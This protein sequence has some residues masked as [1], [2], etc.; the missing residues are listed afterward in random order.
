MS[1]INYQEFKVLLSDFV[2]AKFHDANDHE[3]VYVSRD[4]Y[5]RRLLNVSTG[6]VY[7]NVTLIWD[8]DG[9]LGHDPSIVVAQAD[10]TCNQQV[11]LTVI[12]LV[13]L[14]LFEN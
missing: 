8:V 4:A 3:W 10:M 1:D 5:T 9:Y 13:S 7:T 12:R 2:S 6:H 11:L 14:T